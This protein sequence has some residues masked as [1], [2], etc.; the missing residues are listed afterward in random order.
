MF[1]FVARGHKRYTLVIN[2]ET[3][4]ECIPEGC[5]P[6]AVIDVS[7]KE[8]YPLPERD[9]LDRDPLGQRSVWTKIP[10]VRTETPSPVNR[11]T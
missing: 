6:P 7:V 8:I 5:I 3:K 10:P 9:P 1:S 2:T 4:H 11:Q